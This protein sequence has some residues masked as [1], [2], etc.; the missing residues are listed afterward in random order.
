MKK[1]KSYGKQKMGNRAGNTDFSVKRKSQ[2]GSTDLKTDIEQGFDAS[3]P[4]TGS[5][6][7]EIPGTANSQVK[8][9]AVT[10]GKGKVP[11]GY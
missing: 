5:T 6:Y 10:S 7:K 2:T 9:T 8:E 4:S 11:K 1:H 3:F